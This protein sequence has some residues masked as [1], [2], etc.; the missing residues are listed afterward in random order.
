M[1]SVLVILRFSDVPLIA[2]HRPNVSP[3]VTGVP[4][5]IYQRFPSFAVALAAFL[6][7]AA[8]GTV[9]IV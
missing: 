3:L 5:A 6:D 4:G 9:A 1:V 2:R 8:N 7:A